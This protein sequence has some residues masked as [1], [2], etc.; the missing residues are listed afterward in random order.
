[1]LF[2]KKEEYLQYSSAYNK[3]PELDSGEPEERA[4][5][6]NTP[7]VLAVSK[8]NI[9]LPPSSSSKVDINKKKTDTTPKDRG[10][11]SQIAR[12]TSKHPT[13]L[14]K[15]PKSS[16][17]NRLERTATKSYTQK[18]DLLKSIFMDSSPSLHRQ[19]RSPLP[20]PTRSSPLSTH[21]PSRISTDYG[22]EDELRD[23]EIF[24]HDSV[25]G[26]TPLGRFPNKIL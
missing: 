22:V 7:E 18:D 11:S 20:P 19:K 14:K 8:E 12:S 10:V 5:D 2:S 6:E 23:S 9:E 3:K 16:L 4:N 26:P 13:S 25:W 21:T 17:I 15:T 1:M 24:G